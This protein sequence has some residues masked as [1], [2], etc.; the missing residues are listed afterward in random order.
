MPR[1]LKAAALP[2]LLKSRHELPWEW[3]RPQALSVAGSHAERRPAP[4]MTSKSPIS[5]VIPSRRVTAVTVCVGVPGLVLG[6]G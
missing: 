3:W 2:P 4:Y 5:A 6:C 1:W